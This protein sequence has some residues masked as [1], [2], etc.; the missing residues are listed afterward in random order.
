MEANASGCAPTRT[1][2]RADSSRSLLR[3]APAPSPATLPSALSTVLTS[4]PDGFVGNGWFW[5]PALLSLAPVFPRI[6]TTGAPEGAGGLMVTGP[7]TGTE[8]P[9]ATEPVV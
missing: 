6:T 7:R 4:L 9:A 1:C 8:P 3:G 2:W 5:V